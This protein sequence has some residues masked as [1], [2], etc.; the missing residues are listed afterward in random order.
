MKK[1]SEFPTARQL[2]KW[3]RSMKESGLTPEKIQIR[4]VKNPKVKARKLGSIG[5]SASVKP[6]TRDQDRQ[7]K[8]MVAGHKRYWTRFE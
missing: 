8:D 4:V 1:K 2:A 5:N 6:T 7:V 3:E